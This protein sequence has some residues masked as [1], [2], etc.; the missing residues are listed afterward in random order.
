ME[1]IN[2]QLA[3]KVNVVIYENNNSQDFFG[4]GEGIRMLH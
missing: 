1:K 2:Y 3:S 4:A